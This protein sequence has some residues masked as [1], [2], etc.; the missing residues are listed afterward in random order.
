MRALFIS[1]DDPVPSRDGYGL[2]SRH[3]LSLLEGEVLSAVF[4]RGG[5]PDE[6]GLRTEGLRAWP[7]GAQAL[8][9]ASGVSATRGQFRSRRVT[10]WA[11][12]L[13]DRH[14][15][16]VVILNH[17]RAGWLAPALAAQ[18]S[19][20][21]VYVAHND[22]ARGLGSVAPYMGTWL[23]RTATRR[24]ARTSDRLQRKILDP[25][26]GL[27]TIS[28]ADAMSLAKHHSARL[29][30][31][32]I[33][34]P[35]PNVDSGSAPPADRLLFVGSVT[36]EPKYQNLRWLLQEVLPRVLAEHPSTVVDIVGAGVRRVEPLVSDPRVRLH[37]DVDDVSPYFEAGGVFLVPERQQGGVKLKSIEAAA[38][39]LPIVS[40][41]AGVEGTSLRASNAC[42]VADDRD[43]F[44][45]AIVTLLDDDNKARTLSQRARQ[46]IQDMPQPAEQRTLVTT[47]LAQV[48]QR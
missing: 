18:T 13:I 43:G 2:Y 19:A 20:P 44:A 6:P 35:R 11:L 38:Y 15:P 29:P 3:I 42:L 1:A 8:A 9:V 36:W 10:R 23:L 22:E 14:N 32:T 40:T 34:P 28:D 33:P 47:L 17:I 45:A 37:S 31:V 46:V 24:E 4:G 26:S 41:P 25:L 27:I 7:R 16:D 21:L 12:A 5:D 48:V 30:R 39:G